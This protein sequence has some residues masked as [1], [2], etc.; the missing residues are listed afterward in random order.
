MENKI[1]RRQFIGTAARAA[2]AL[3][4]MLS[5]ALAAV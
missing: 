4:G 5:R 3:P 2:L 1:P